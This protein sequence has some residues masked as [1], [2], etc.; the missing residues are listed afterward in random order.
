ME[1]FFHISRVGLTLP[2]LASLKLR[3]VPLDALGA[4]SLLRCPKLREL[5][6]MFGKAGWQMGSEDVDY[7]DVFRDHVGS[8]LAAF[9]REDPTSDSTLETIYIE[10]G[11]FEEDTLFKCLQPL[12]SIT[13]L[14]LAN[15][16]F[17][18]DLF[19]KLS[20]PSMHLPQLLVMTILSPRLQDNRF[21]TIQRVRSFAQERGVS[22]WMSPEMWGGRYGQCRFELVKCVLTSRILSQ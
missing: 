17:S 10:H 15:V 11:I 1:W 6:I 3:Q 5:A 9:L 7:S 20:T 21:Q 18:P 16:A 12:T 2:Q 19:T 8:Q 13:H 4:L 14:T 22:L